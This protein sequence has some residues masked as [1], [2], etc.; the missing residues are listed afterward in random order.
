[1]TLTRRRFLAIAAAFAGSPALAQR[2]SWQGFALG[3]E[4]S[5]TLTGPVQL[6]EPILERAKRLIK[7]VEAAFSLYD[8]ASALTRLNQAKQLQPSQRFHTLMTLADAAFQVTDGL[9]DPTVQP[10]WQ[11]LADGGATDKALES[12]GWERVEF[13][14]DHIALQSDQALTFNGI[15]QGFATDLVAEMLDA[16]G[17]D[18]ALINIGEYRSTGGTWRL[19]IKDA[20]HGLL[21][22]RSLTRGAIATSDTGTSPL[23]E[24]GHILHPT[25][26]PQW[27]SVSVEA[28]TAAWADALS[29]ALTLAPLDQVRAIKAAA[30]LRRVTLVS[31]DG[32]LTTL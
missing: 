9:F 23:R 31:F 10:L 20:Q 32:E 8:P 12:I 4:V 19:G 13:T 30:H 21:G 6:A 26:R 17:F 27:S 28:D 2:H 15:A 11:A 22:Q 29:T 1:M 18:A 25:A 3:A 16:N 7:D 24:R 5:I 14:P